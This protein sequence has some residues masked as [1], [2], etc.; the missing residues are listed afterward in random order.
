MG[1][2]IVIMVRRRPKVEHRDKMA[3]NELPLVRTWLPAQKTMLMHMLI[4]KDHPNQYWKLLKQVINTPEWEV[5]QTV[6]PLLYPIVL[7]I[8]WSFVMWLWNRRGSRPGQLP[9]AAHPF[10]EMEALMG[11]RPSAPPQPASLYPRLQ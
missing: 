5:S 3:N 4:D 9:E 7:K 10:V 11:A 1:M 6:L 2:V 8:F